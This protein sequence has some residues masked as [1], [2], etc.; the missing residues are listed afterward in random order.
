MRL[1]TLVR[2]IFWSEPPPFPSTFGQLGQLFGSHTQTIVADSEDQKSVP[3]LSGYAYL[4]V[5]LHTGNPCVIAFS[6]M[7]CRMNFSILYFSAESGTSVYAWN[8]PG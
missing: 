6:T 7:G 8:F 5:F 3:G 2:P 4:S 1:L